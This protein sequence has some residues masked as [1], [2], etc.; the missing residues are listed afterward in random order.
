MRSVIRFLFNVH[1]FGA[2]AF[3]SF[4]S[5][6][7]SLNDNRR[8]FD[9]GNTVTELKYKYSGQWTLP[10]RTKIK[11]HI[12]DTARSVVTLLL[13]FLARLQCLPLTLQ[14]ARLRI[15]PTDTLNQVTL[16]QDLSVLSYYF[17]RITVELQK[18]YLPNV[19]VVSSWDYI[20]SLCYNLKIFLFS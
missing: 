12:V 1:S 7:F 2:S 16:N 5:S 6:Y 13:D 17:F 19:F 9:N 11:I 15:L 4:I 18:K 3:T 8:L 14:T 10:P 20:A